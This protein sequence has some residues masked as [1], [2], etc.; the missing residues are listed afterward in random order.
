MAAELNAF[1]EAVGRADRDQA[2]RVAVEDVLH[3]EQPCGDLLF[4]MM[5]D[6]GMHILDGF[7]CFFTTAHT[8][9]RRRAIVKA[10]KES[11]ARDAGGRLLARACEDASTTGVASTPTSRRCRA[12]AWAATPTAT[13]PGTCRTRPSPE[14]T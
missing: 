8:R 10:F 12:R 2:L 4:A 13:P 7:P 5:R 3:E 9:S 14:S 1:F 11:V 6:R